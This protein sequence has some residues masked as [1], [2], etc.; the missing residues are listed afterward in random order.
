MMYPLMLMQGNNSLSFD[1]DDYVVSS[2]D[3]IIFNG[4]SFHGK[5]IK[6]IWI[7]KQ[8]MLSQYSHQNIW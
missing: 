3:I 7:T 4:G 1:E 2:N 8:V 6:L 5:L